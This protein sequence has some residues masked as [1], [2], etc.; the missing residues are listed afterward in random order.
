M[1]N[2]INY[3]LISFLGLGIAKLKEYDVL[4]GIDEAGRGCIAGPLVVSGVIR[5]KKYRGFG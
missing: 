5:F 3:T 1:T 4:C 2:S